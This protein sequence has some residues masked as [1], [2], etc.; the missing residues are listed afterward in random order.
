MILAIAALERPRQGSERY[1]SDVRRLDALTSHTRRADLAG[2]QTSLAVVPGCS[3]SRAPAE[4]VF[5]SGLGDLFVFR[6]ARSV[7]APSQVGS[8]ER[9]LQRYGA[10]LVPVLGHTNCWAVCAMIEALPESVTRFA[11]H[12][13]KSA[14][15]Q[16]D[17]C[18]MDI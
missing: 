3:D 4:L 13:L 1:A 5:D 8:V 18:Q 12:F 7:A 10:R 14:W 16:P 11:G 9:A 6:V 15:K 2:A 17:T